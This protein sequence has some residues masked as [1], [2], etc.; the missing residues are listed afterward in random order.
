M[1]V[2][3]AMTVHRLHRNPSTGKLA[4]N[5]DTGK[6]QTFINSMAA[7]CGDCFG[8][9]PEKITA[10]FEGISFA[11]GCLISGTSSVSVDITLSTS[12]YEVPFFDGFPPYTSGCFY[13]ENPSFKDN[14]GAS[15]NADFYNSPN[16]DCEDPIDFSWDIFGTRVV[17]EVTPT[18]VTVAMHIVRDSGGGGFILG[19]AFSGSTGILDPSERC[20]QGSTPTIS[21]TLT[22]DGT[23][24]VLGEG[25]TV[26]L[27]I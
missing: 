20:F 4:R 14:G 19:P 16:D 9:Q 3:C 23:A 1:W 25:G 12:S 15:G 13:V 24:S 2:Y 5:P 11:S 7:E 6:L 18:G 27:T 21:N 10:V 22:L 17:I 26:R 8:T